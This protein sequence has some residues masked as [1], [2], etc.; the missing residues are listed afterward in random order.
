MKKQTIVWLIACFLVISTIGIGLSMTDDTSQAAEDGEIDEIEV[1]S[2]ECIGEEMYDISVFKGYGTGDSEMFEEG[3]GLEGWTFELWRKS[4][5]PFGS[6]WYLVAS[7][8]T[9]EEGWVHFDQDSI[10]ESNY[11]GSLECFPSPW[12]YHFKVREI[13]KDGWYFVR[14][15]IVSGSSG[16]GDTD[17]DVEDGYVEKSFQMYK[18]DEMEIHFYNALEEEERLPYDL[19]VYKNDGETNMPIEGWGFELYKENLSNPGEWLFIFSGV[20]DET[21]SIAF[22]DLVW[23]GH[24]KVREYLDE[25]WYFTGGLVIGGSEDGSEDFYQGEGY[26]EKTFYFECD[27]YVEIHFWNVYEKEELGDLMIYKFHDVNYDG[28][29]DEEIDYLMDGFEFQLWEADEEGNPIDTIGDVVETS[30]GMYTFEDLEAGYY[31][32]QELIREAEEGCC[33][34]STTGKFID[35]LGTLIAVE[36]ETEG[37]AEAWFGNVRGGNIQGMKF[38]SVEGNEEFIVGLDKPLMGWPI[39]LWT[40]EDGSPSEVVSTTITDRAGE[41]RFEC[42]VPGEYFVQEEMWDGWYNVTPDIQHVYVEPCTTVEG[43]D[44]ANCMYKDI[45]GI[46]FYDYTMDSEFTEDDWVLEGWEINLWN[47]IDGEPGD[48]IYTTHTLPNGYYFFDGL[49]VGTYYVEEVI[50]EGWINTTPSLVKVEFNCCTPCYPVN[51][52]N[53]EL[54]RITIIKFNDTDMDGQYNRDFEH[55][56]DSEVLFSIDNLDLQTR[57]DRIVIGEWTSYV[58]LGNYMITEH[59]PEGWVNTTP[60][61][62]MTD[63]PLGPGDHWIVEFGN[64]QFGDIEVFKF[65]D[66]NMNSEFDEEYEYGLE[67]WTFNLWSTI[68]ENDSPRPDEILEANVTDENGFAMFWEYGPG[69]YAVEEIIEAGWYPTTDIIQYVE[70][71]PGE[72]VTVEFGNV[73]LGCIEVFKFHDL[74]MDSEFDEEYEYGLEGWTFNLWT[75]DD[76]EID[77]SI[78]HGVSDDEGFVY[79]EELLPGL[80]AVQEEEQDCW[81]PTTDTVQFIEIGPGETGILQFG[82]VEGASIHGFKFCDVNLNQ[83][84]DD[85]ECGLEGWE[86]RLTP[87]GE[88]H[89][90]PH[91]GPEYMYTYTDENGYFEF[92]CLM[93]GTYLLEEIIQ[94]GWYNST[95]DHYEVELLPGDELRYD[96]GNY[97]YGDITGLKFFDFTMS[98]IFEPKE[99]DIPLR[100]REVQLWTSDEDGNPTGD[101]PIYT[102]ETDEHGIYIFED[103]GPGDYV[104]YQPKPCCDWEHTTPRQQHV[105]MGCVEEKIVNFGE[106]KYSSIDV[107]VICGWEGIEVMIYESDEYGEWHELLES[108]YTG[109]HGWYISEQLAPGYYIVELGDGQYEHVQL[110]MGEQVEFEYNNDIPQGMIFAE[111]IYAKIE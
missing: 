76:G 15:E 61:V 29:Y 75:T 100:G 20:T 4:Y 24:Y 53:Y 73:Q 87:M 47:D 82:N 49:K 8:T 97:R 50:P 101:E 44:F 86:I 26:V 28:I 41:Y 17:F 84:F 79:F 56:V 19:K 77:I 30:E 81:F 109:E 57:D 45:Y 21:G 16:E 23:N 63:Q 93:P 65:H 14:G 35:D 105:R 27:P 7:G 71:I 5:V 69:L 64:V 72:T 42:L 38:L 108:G 83:E 68:M 54:P 103:V 31:V 51:F 18:G 59:L 60:L 46:K 1:E 3:E 12:N 10:V 66:L 37:T 13:M 22:Y 88:N 96:F 106:Y 9:C 111:A 80:Y 89:A 98:G 94:P 99:G 85:D 33:W 91:I 40:A 104:V 55:L 110:R 58:E 52:G 78:E 11:D 25:Y 36:V 90:V 74:N 107:Y 2:I 67:G 102:T 48:I 92:V 43:V 32:V 39:N 34:V 70:I 62:Q 95:P 6:P